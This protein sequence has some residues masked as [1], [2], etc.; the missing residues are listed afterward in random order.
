VETDGDFYYKIALTYINWRK[1]G[2]NKFKNKYFIPLLLK[3]F[4]YGG[5]SFRTL[6][7]PIEIFTL[8]EKWHMDFTAFVNLRILWEERS[9]LCSTW[10]CW[11]E[12]SWCYS[13]GTD[14]CRGICQRSHFS[15]D[16][17]FWLASTNIVPFLIPYSQITTIQ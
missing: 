6:K 16:T 10:S 1:F 5:F 15:D 7:K 2:W 11:R 13:G 12:S 14:K 9:Y 17:K 3:I 8:S 4:Q